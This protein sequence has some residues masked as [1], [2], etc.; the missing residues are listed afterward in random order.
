MLTV[1]TGNNACTHTI[2]YD[3]ICLGTYAFVDVLIK[4]RQDEG[5]KGYADANK[6]Q[7][8]DTQRASLH[9][10]L[11]LVTKLWLFYSYRKYSFPDRQSQAIHVICYFG[12]P[13]EGSVSYATTCKSCNE[14]TCLF[15]KQGYLKLMDYAD[16]LRVKSIILNYIIH[17]KKQGFYRVIRVPN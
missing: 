16:Y 4:T 10:S 6:N 12:S 2:R 9:K 5:N 13:R 1:H 3:P 17:S 11:P 8:K 15:H 7:S 14:S